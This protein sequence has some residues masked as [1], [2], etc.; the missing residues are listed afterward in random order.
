MRVA[1]SVSAAKSSRLWSWLPQEEKVE[2]KYRRII[3]EQLNLLVQLNLHICEVGCLMKKKSKRNM[4]G[5]CW[6]SW[7][8]QCS[9][10]FIIYLWSWLP[11]YA[12]AE[13]KHERILSDS[14]R[15]CQCSWIFV[16]VKLAGLRKKMQKRSME[17]FC[18]SS[19][20]CRCSRIFISVKKKKQKWR[21][22]KREAWKDSVRAKALWTWLWMLN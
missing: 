22:S 8:C 21:R 2:E 1:E 15:I 12:G 7:I 18:Q 9:R 14:S 5:F 16:S 4:K 6:S 19:R 20:I 10:I 3:L 17:G 11:H 13:E